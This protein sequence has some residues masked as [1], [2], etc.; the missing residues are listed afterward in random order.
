[1]PWRCCMLAFAVL[2]CLAAAASATAHEFS[3]EII[4]LQAKE[5][6]LARE[7]GDAEAAVLSDQIV[8]LIARE[9][10]PESEETT[11]AEQAAALANERAGDLGRAVAHGQAA[12]RLQEAIYG[13]GSA[14]LVQTLLGLGDDLIRLNRIDEAE[15]HL[16]LALKLGVDTFGPQHRF[17]V[18]AYTR[19]GDL[20]MARGEI[21][22]ALDSYR[23]ATG[24]LRKG[25]AQSAVLTRL[26]AQELRHNQD[27]FIGIA[28]AN[29]ANRGGG[30]DV[31]A[32]AIEESFAASQEAWATAAARALAKM[33][34]R[35]GAGDTAFGRAIAKADRLF[36]KALALSDADM[37]ALAAWSKVQAANPAYRQ[38]LDEFRKLSIENARDSA[39]FSTRQ[40]ELIAQ[41]QALATRC[42]GVAK[43]GCE[44][45]PEQQATIAR[46]LSDL[47]AHTQTGTGPLMEVYRK[48]QSAEAQLPGYAAFTKAR[49]VR[50]TDQQAAESELKQVQAALARDYPDY[51]ELIS[52][53][54]LSI[55][56]V[57]RLLRDDEVLVAVLTGRDASFVWAVTREGANWAEIKAGIAEIGGDVL[58]LRR[59]LDTDSISTPSHDDVVGGF[60]LA[61]AHRLYDMLLGP[62]EP[63]LKGKHHVV[64]V[65]TGP[66]T[67]LPFQVLL[68][69]PPEPGLSGADAFKGAHWL[70]RDYALS[71]LPSVQSLAVL[72]QRA[73]DSHAPEPFLGIGDPDL[74]KAPLGQHERPAPS[75]GI[76]ASSLTRGRKL[77]DPRDFLQLAPLPETADELRMIARELKAPAGSLWLGQD[78]TV[79][80]VKQAD[81]TRYR[82]IEFS[83]HGLV[84]GDLGIEEPALVLTPPAAPSSL[85]DGLLSASEVAALRLDADWVVLSACNT[86]AGNHTGADALSGLARAFFFAGARALLVSH[87][88]VESNSAVSLT[89]GAF[90]ALAADPK[91]GR[92]E[93]MRRSML[94][95]IDGAGSNYT[96]PSFWAPFVVVGEAGSKR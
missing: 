12:L 83:T 63:R 58:A 21:T 51:A 19:L 69:V 9:T 24:L 60:D 65:P 71:V 57:Q 87:W 29:W 82:A 47:S 43:A 52:P 89:T 11:V 94:A 88:P 3:E 36:A 38:L 92:A 6:E 40:K 61:L 31:G 48:M 86:A 20:A 77:V 81:L 64:L 68:T 78:A 10:G 73:G 41:L 14:V 45:A 35:L 28:S 16:R 75:K 72:R 80:H 2:V 4:R 32:A 76:L 46:E 23:Q 42:A 59:G 17:N 18:G 30:V 44:K 22:V 27:A 54:T 7:G 37:A 1:M 8:Q 50:I 62:L 39:P 66:L 15:P 95:L 5:Q 79:T 84:A 56:D 55:A 85:D 93:A 13:P 67:S 49:E 26:S 25:G 74:G 33:A 91:I 34:A 90:G 96:H 53:H 70:I